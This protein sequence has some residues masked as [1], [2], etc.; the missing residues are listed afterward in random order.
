[1][2]KGPNCKNFRNSLCKSN[3]CDGSL[4]CYLNDAGEETRMSE[5]DLFFPNFFFI[6]LVSFLF[7]FDGLVELFVLRLNDNY[8]CLTNIILIIL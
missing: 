6:I 5:V 1:M 3:D 4:H 7:K 2:S 8:L